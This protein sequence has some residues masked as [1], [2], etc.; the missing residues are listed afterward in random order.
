VQGDPTSEPSPA[1]P[2]LDG[3]GQC[4]LTHLML[5]P[6]DRRHFLVWGRVVGT[7]GVNEPLI[8]NINWAQPLHPASL[9][10]TKTPSRIVEDWNTRRQGREDGF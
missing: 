1:G 5:M 9:V 6:D 7:G 8:I 3:S 4:T 10:A 2:D